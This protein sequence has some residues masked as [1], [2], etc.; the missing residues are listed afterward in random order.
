MSHMRSRGEGDHGSEGSSSDSLKL[1]DC[2][3]TLVSNENSNSNK[4]STRRRCRNR[5]RRISGEFSSSSSASEVIITRR[6][7]RRR[8]VL[9]DE[10]ALLTFEP[11]QPNA[12][13]ARAPAA[14]SGRIVTTKRWYQVPWRNIC[15]V[16]LSVIVLI[17]FFQTYMVTW[18]TGRPPYRFNWNLCALIICCVLM[19]ILMSQDLK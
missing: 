17:L 16:I 5:R 15:F 8:G 4:V 18:I 12:A 2:P 1:A 19:C 3:Q 10:D 14:A 11:Y 6:R 9:S 7:H 13:L